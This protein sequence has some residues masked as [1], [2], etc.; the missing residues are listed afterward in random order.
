MS[1]PLQPNS[2]SLTRQELYEKVWTVSMR[3]L[4]AEYGLSDVGLAKTCERH[5]IPRPPVRYWAFLHCD[6]SQ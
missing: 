1:T 6:R 5:E 3:K 4:A 2:S